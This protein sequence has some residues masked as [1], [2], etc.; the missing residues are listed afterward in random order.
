[1]FLFDLYNLLK[2]SYMFYMIFILSILFF[3]ENNINRNY[4]VLNKNGT[5]IAWLLCVYINYC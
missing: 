2:F 3:V 4:T 1:M 5:A